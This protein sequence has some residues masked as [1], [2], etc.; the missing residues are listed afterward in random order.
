MAFC[1]TQWLIS[2]R[3]RIRKCRI[4]KIQCNML[5]ITAQEQVRV[6]SCDIIS[7]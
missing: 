2:A 1:M 3:L 6:G 7:H 5:I 4:L